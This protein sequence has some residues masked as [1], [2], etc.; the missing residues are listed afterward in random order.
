MVWRWLLCCA[1]LR[2]AIQENYHLLAILRQTGM[3]MALKNLS[4]KITKPIFAIF[5]S[6]LFRICSTH[7]TMWKSDTEWRKHW[8]ER[9]AMT[10]IKLFH[11][12]EISLKRNQ[13]WKWNLNTPRFKCQMLKNS[14]Q[15]AQSCTVMRQSNH[16]LCCLIDM[17]WFIKFMS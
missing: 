1:N 3:S 17:I 6:G 8:N 16:S 15:I 5:W 2:I 12:E 9:L 11:V 14:L 10:L 7:P 4:I 13:N